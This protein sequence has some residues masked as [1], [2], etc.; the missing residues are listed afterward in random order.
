MMYQ[1]KQKSEGFPMG[2][3]S[4]NTPIGMLG[5]LVGATLD[6]S[7]IQNAVLRLWVAGLGRYRT[8]ACAGVLCDRA[9]S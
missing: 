4:P 7:E 8:Q 1:K 5:H 6:M 2:S 9:G 3:K